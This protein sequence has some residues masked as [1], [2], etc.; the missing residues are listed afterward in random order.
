MKIDIC[1]VEVFESGNAEVVVRKMGD[2]Y[3]LSGRFGL[4]YHKWR[5]NKAWSIDVNSLE[6]YN[7]YLSGEMVRELQKI[8]DFFNTNIAVDRF[9]RTLVKQVLTEIEVDTSLEL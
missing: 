6:N 4:S 3:H 7:E 9:K 8:L 5:E 2:W 1:K